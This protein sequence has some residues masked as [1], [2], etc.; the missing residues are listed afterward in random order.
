MKL[1][2]MAGKGSG[3]MGSMVYVVRKGEQVV[4]QYNPKI[5][6]PSTD[7]QVEQRA[8][9]K[10]LT[11][12]GQI[13]A[14]GLLLVPR[15]AET[16]RNRFMAVNM[17]MIEWDSATGAAIANYNAMKISEGR[18]PITAVRT[19]ES[20][21]INVEVAGDWDGLALGVL[22]S[23]QFDTVFGSGVIVNETTTTVPV[24]AALQN[25]TTILV[26]AYRFADDAAR[27]RYT[28]MEQ[29]QSMSE[30]K[31]NVEKMVREGEIITSATVVAQA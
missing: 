5:M 31:V 13:L 17:R 22:T 6:N 9:F 10:L 16:K 26:A 20:D 11:Q 4:R 29:G 2:G 18:T 27:T 21:G 12:L 3:R 23:P 30:L 28:E 8:K 14:D 19:N 1:Y 15:G 24:P 25:R 7:R